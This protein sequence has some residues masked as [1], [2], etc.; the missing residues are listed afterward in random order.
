M[1]VHWTISHPARLV[2]AVA[3]GDV[4]VADF[5]QYFAGVTADG[6]MSYRKI[7]EITHAPTALTEEN[8]KALGQRV[9][10]YAQHGQV[11]PVAIVAATDESFRQAEVFATASAGVRRPLMIFRELHAAR[12]WLDEQSVPQ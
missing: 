3:K 1:P 4:T 12:R 5:E 10:Y 8:L 11:G 6:A 9:M 2:M 7:F